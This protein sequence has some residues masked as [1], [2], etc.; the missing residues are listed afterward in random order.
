M[1]NEFQIKQDGNK[2][3]ITTKRMV[4]KFIDDGYPLS[5]LNIRITVFNKP[6]NYEWAMHKKD[7][8]NLGGTLITLDQIT[9][10]V[11][12]SN[13]LLS[14]NGCQLIDDS[15]KEI[16]VD[17]WIAERSVNHLSD[18]YFFAYGNDYKTALKALSTISGEVPMN[19]KYIHGSWYCRWWDYSAD[20]FLEIAKGYK[21]HDFPLDV[22]VLDMGWHTQ[23]DATTGLGNTDSYGWTGYSW[24]KKLFPN[25]QGLLNKLK[26]DGLA[27]AL[28]DHPHDGIR[29][30]E[31]QYPNFMKAMGEDTTGKKDLLF[32]AGNKKYMENFFKY[33][34]Q[35]LENMGVD[36]WWL[37]WQQDMEMPYVLGYRTLRHLP[38]LNNLYF[39]NSERDNKRGLLFSRWAGWG[40]HRTPIQFSGDAKSTWE[41]L[42]FE[43]PFTT[44]SGNVGCFFWAHDIGGFFGDRNPE[45]YVRWTQFGLTNS[46]LRIH[47]T[48]DSKLD[49]R[50]WLWGEQAEIAM[51]KVYHLRS[52]LMPYIYSSVWQCHSQTI[53]LNRGMYIEYP[54]KEEAYNNPQQYLFGDL[55]LSAPI[56]SPGTGKDLIAN[57]KVW[58]PEG[59]TWFNIFN[60]KKYEGG[61]TQD[62]SADINESP[63]FVKG[64]YP[65]PMQPYRQ[66]MA[67]AKL[68]TLVIRCYPGTEGKKNMFTLYEDDGVSTDYLKGKNAFNNLYY[69]QAKNGAD[70]TIDAVAGQGYKDQP[71]KRAYQIELLGVVMKGAKVNGKSRKVVWRKDLNA[72]VVTIPST[73]I[74][75][76]I[77]VNLFQ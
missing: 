59:D 74:K 65:L 42:K 6:K 73:T 49:R 46:S 32:N 1:S 53:P 43:V 21:E 11:P 17:G 57:Q 66:R 31:D 45:Q 4:V 2:Y 48:Y 71:L 40:S 47:S 12:T 75:Q 61:T 44:N 63:L 37:D 16:F 30:H 64:G 5:N 27:I 22:M 33:A 70:I 69:L 76:V 29:H 28:N 8:K 25:P 68:D 10:E 77:T 51:R 72:S 14:R 58:F 62:V 55:L 18:F 41:L 23:K 54:D 7:N 35:P 56:V 9:G 15:R 39:K 3:T 34:Q 38:W 67:T 36:F 20:E 24:N 26:D 60:H 13:G 50:P 19:R 52:Q